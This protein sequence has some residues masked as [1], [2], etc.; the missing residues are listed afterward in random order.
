M[1]ILKSYHGENRGKAKQTN[2]RALQLKS[3]SII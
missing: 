1:R 3:L 2:L